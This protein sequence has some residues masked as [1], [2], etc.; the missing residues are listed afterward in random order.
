[1]DLYEQVIRHFYYDCQTLNTPLG[2]SA[3]CFDGKSKVQ[4]T[5]Y[6]CNGARTGAYFSTAPFAGAILSL[7]FLHETLT[8]N[9]LAVAGFMAFGVWLHLTETQEHGH[10]HEEEEHDHLP[11]HD[12]HHQHEHDSEVAPGGPHSHWHRHVAITHSHPHYPDTQ[13]RHDH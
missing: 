4:W 13:H 7:L 2:L 10:S 9:L 5:N 11:T 12:E 1:M 6:N 8:I 3:G